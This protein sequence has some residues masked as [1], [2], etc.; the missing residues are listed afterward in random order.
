VVASIKMKVA[1]T[2]LAFATALLLHFWGGWTVLALCVM[3][4]TSLLLIAVGTEPVEAEQQA[5]ATLINDEV[6]HARQIYK[7]LL[8]E[9]DELMAECRNS[10]LAINETQND[11][12][13]TLTNSFSNLK[14][15]TEFQSEEI[16]S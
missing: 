16:F 7:Q 2:L 10:I 11:A 12:V 13:N 15:L 3:L 4:I 6:Q 8:H 1:F 9:I 5:Q 14:N